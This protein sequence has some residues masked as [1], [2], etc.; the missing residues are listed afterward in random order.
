M[1]PGPRP[2]AAPH[3]MPT[4]RIIVFDL[5]GV[6][7][8]ICRSWKEA[9]AH[10]GLPFHDIAA[11]PDN[12]AQRKAIVRLHEVGAISCSDYYQQIAATTDGLYTPQQVATLH[13][14]WIIGQYPGIDTLIDD[15]H[16][17]GLATGILSNTNAHH[18]AQMT[19]P[20]P[21][22]P[23]QPS[24]FPAVTKPLHP[25]ASHLLKLAKPDK[26]IFDAF[27]HATG[28]DPHQ[29]LFFDDLADNVAGAAAAGWDAV[30]IDHTAD[31]ASQVRLHLRLRG[32]DL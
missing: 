26:A 11:T 31:P 19:T 23:G 17:L 21:D 7:V 27:N 30:Q 18:W 1:T 6:V 16:A 10:A 2:P 15:L 4:P 20:H 3:P 25:H 32:I 22:H 29:T 13:D 28:L 12:I 9:C 14:R 5:G 24:K 8:R